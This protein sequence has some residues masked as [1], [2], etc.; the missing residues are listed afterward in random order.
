M[1]RLAWQLS[2]IARH[3]CWGCINPGH[4]APGPRDSGIHRRANQDAQSGA[5]LLCC[6][7]AWQ[8]IRTRGLNT[9]PLPSGWLWIFTPLPQLNLSVGTPTK[10]TQAPKSPP[11][12]PSAPQPLSP[13]TIHQRVVE[14][15]EIGRKN[16]SISEGRRC[17]ISIPRPPHPP[18]GV[19]RSAGGVQWCVPSFLL[20]I[21]SPELVKAGNK[22]GQFPVITLNLEQGHSH[23]M[24]GG[25][26]QAIDFSSSLCMRLY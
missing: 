15:K 25:A 11:P 7:M 20:Q 16:R 26:L 1:A 8:P 2:H 6:A 4:G 22:K 14:V 9:G 13:Q 3:P 19:L 5:R 17:P 10:P 12:Q 24:E 18:T 21:P 23:L